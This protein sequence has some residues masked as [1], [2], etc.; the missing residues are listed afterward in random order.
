MLKKA[1][2]YIVALGFLVLAVYSCKKQ[3][4]YPIIP[5][6]KF[7]DFLLHYNSGINAYDIGVLT[8]TFKDGDGDIGLKQHELD[9]PYDYNFFISL[10]EIK[11]GDSA[12]YI[13]VIYNPSTQTFDTLTFNQR[14]PMLTPLGPDKSI[15]GTIE[16]TLYIFS[17]D[18]PLDTVFFKVSIRDRALHESNTI[19][20]P[21]MKLGI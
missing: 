17:P 8:I 10:Y 2:I 21:L 7:E 11:N 9:P 1:F 3:E 16:D 12:E 15:S 13:P 5:E 4:T 18:Y 14:I 20:T 19:Y 6:I